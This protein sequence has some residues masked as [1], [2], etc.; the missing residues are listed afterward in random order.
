MGGG[1][2]GGVK[3]NILQ[4]VKDT[5]QNLKTLLQWPQVWIIGHLS[6]V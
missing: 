2:G 4:K 1:G 6:H 5:I 3:K